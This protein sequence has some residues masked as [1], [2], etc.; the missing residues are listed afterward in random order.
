[1]VR[2]ADPTEGPSPSP[3]SVTKRDELYDLLRYSS[4]SERDE[5]RRLLD[6]PRNWEPLPGPQTTAYLSDADELYYGGGAGGGK[7]DLL[8]GLAATE[9]RRSILFRRQF[10]QLSE[11]V[12][13]SRALYAHLG[14][15]RDGSPALWRFHDGRLI[16]LG[17]MDQV[18]DRQKYM[19]RPHD[20]IGWDELASFTEGQ[21]RFVNGW[22]RTTFLG[23]R[24]R[25][26]GVGNP[27]T[28]PEGR[29]V[30]AHWAP[31]LD[32][33]HANPALPG[34]LRWFAMLAGEE[35]ELENGDS[36]L[37]PDGDTIA[38]R[39]RTF[40]PSRVADNP[41]LLRTGYGAVLDALPEPLRSQLKSG[42][43]SA[44]LED[45][46]WQIIPTAWV[47]AAM[48]RWSPEGRGPLA[49]DTIG[50]DVARGGRAKT[51]IS[52]RYG[53]WFAPLERHPGQS[54]PD[55]PAVARLLIPIILEEGGVVHVDVIGV[56]SAVYDTL[57]AHDQ[58]VAAINFAE[59]SPWTDRSGRLRMANVRAECYWRM[60]EALDP[61]RGDSLQ[62][63][64]DAELLAD[65]CA[66]RWQLR[67]SGIV[68]EPK[69][70][71]AERI[72][73]S[74]DAGDAVV[75]AHLP[76]RSGGITFI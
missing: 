55:G 56:G 58:P 47:R 21:Y 42:D 24:C 67:A 73:R 66:A 1:M 43:F 39:S 8:L 46:E 26:V 33:Q 52:R 63:P 14:R 2:S 36:F 28:E 22:N 34:E 31:W 51:V 48:A 30:I 61:E 70:E 23:Q 60:R 68:V 50:C 5:I 45:P 13:R 19:G 15:F 18:R 65:L 57:R 20:L 7:T 17:G 35:V 44:G 75:M 38:P 29:W 9:H 53:P 59:S 12:E 49:C 25:I 32:P 54:T 16:E 64:P 40:I 74:P 11:L 3:I 71:I 62:L 72:G 37:G 76:P 69:E 4:A 6:S 27:P 41:Y 10:T